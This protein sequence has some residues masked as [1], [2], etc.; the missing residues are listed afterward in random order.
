MRA[1]RYAI[2]VTLDGCCDHRAIPTDEELHRHFAEKLAQADA[3]LFGRVTYEMMEA[4]WRAPAT[5]GS[6]AVLSPRLFPTLDPLL[7]CSFSQ[8]F[9]SGCRFRLGPLD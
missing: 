8:Q 4:A 2:N 5:K 3:L 1:L 6:I 9:G 7:G